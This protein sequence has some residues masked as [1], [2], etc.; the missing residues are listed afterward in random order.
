MDRHCWG[1]E[2][3]KEPIFTSAP[4]PSLRPRAD[5]LLLDDKRVSSKDF[6]H[7]RAGAL[8]SRTSFG[9]RDKKAQPAGSRV[10]WKDLNANQPVSGVISK[11]RTTIIKK[12]G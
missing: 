8:S 11:G 1:K 10:S 5:G 12:R 3:H 6:T 2:A 9:P 4:L 7:L